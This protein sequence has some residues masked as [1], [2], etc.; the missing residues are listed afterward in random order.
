VGAVD[1][2]IAWQ[3]V[4]VSLGGP[5]ICVSVALRAA[6]RFRPIS[7]LEERMKR[8]SWLALLAAAWLAWTGSTRGD[9]PPTAP[10]AELAKEAADK[11]KDADKAEEPKF[12]RIRRSD[13]KEVVA[14]D[15]AV[16]RYVPAGA[17][18]EGVTVDLVGAVHIG[19][20]SYY[21]DLNKLFTDYEVVLYELVAPEGTRV[22]KE[23]RKGGNAHPIGAMQNGMS[24]ML[25]LVHQ[26]DCVDYTQANFV[27]ADMSPDEFNKSMTDRGESFMQMFL[28]L[29][30]QGMAQQ[31]RAQQEGGGGSSD[32]NLLVA[33]FSRDRATKLKKLMAEQFEN[34]ESQM[35]VFDGPGG[36]TIIT[37]RNKKAFEV[38]D[39]E[40]K[41]GKKKIAVFYGAGHLPDMEKRLVADF[42]LKRD[43]ERWLTAWTLEKQ[44]AEKKDALKQDAGK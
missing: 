43:S 12:I 33:L 36:S 22:P 13:Q 21:D 2:A 4:A 38:L 24:S 32:L 17:D 41:A 10:A 6:I 25:E 37:E 34:M 31:A 8:P 1:Q 14:M 16:V 19:D 27:H 40:L 20:K 39:K 30:G 7:T 28:R 29:M 11:A 5:Y 18:R 15:T 35:L 44:A 3:I 42:G 23:G 26:L 9:E